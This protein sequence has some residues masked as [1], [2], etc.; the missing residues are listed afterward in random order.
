M[1]GTFNS[2]KNQYQANYIQHALTGDDKYKQIYEAAQKKIESILD[3]APPTE[4]S[5]PLKSTQERSYTRVHQ[6]PVSSIPTQG[7]KYWALGS[8]LLLSFA[9][10]MF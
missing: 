10:S 2:A 8:L 9:L 4:E 1:E 3:K 7:W 6:D 5:E